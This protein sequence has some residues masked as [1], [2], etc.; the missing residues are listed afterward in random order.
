MID[1]GIDRQMEQEQI[2]RNI[3]LQMENDFNAIQDAKKEKAE[4]N[5]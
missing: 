4:P 2:E 3:D 5:T 1:K